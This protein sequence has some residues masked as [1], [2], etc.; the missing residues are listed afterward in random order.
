MTS[1]PRRWVRDHSTLRV[2]AHDT[3]V[4]WVDPP[5]RDAPYADVTT[6]TRGLLLAFARIAYP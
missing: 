4:V 3:R 2:V 6:T 5:P 1:G